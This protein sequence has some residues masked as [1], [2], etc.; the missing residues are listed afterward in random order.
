MATRDEEAQQQ[1]RHARFTALP[2]RKHLLAS[3]AILQP[4]LPLLPV[5]FRHAVQ[6][7]ARAAD[8]TSDHRQLALALQ[9]CEEAQRMSPFGFDEDS[10]PTDPEAAE[11]WAEQAV[12]TSLS[13]NVRLTSRGDEEAENALLDSDTVTMARQAAFDCVYGPWENPPSIAPLWLTWNAETVLKIATGI[14]TDRAF[15]R[16]PLLAD[17]L[18]DAGCDNVQILAHCR[19]PGPHA[20]GCWVVEVLLEKRKSPRRG[21]PAGGRDR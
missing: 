3:M 20:P 19:G 14:Y 8:G 11:W 5:R 1:A 21:S 16:L 9:L 13:E 18:E 17:A 6:I 12:L 2:R 10:L 7:A 4:L 15:D